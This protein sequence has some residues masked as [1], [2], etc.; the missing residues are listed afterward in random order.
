MILSSHMAGTCCTFGFFFF[1]FS[2]GDKQFLLV[3]ISLTYEFISRMRLCYCVINTRHIVACAVLPKVQNLPSMCDCHN[4]SCSHNVRYTEF[5]R[6]HD[7]PILTSLIIIHFQ[8]GTFKGLFSYTVPLFP[9]YFVFF[10]KKAQK[11]H[12]L[13]QHT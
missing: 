13:L 12:Y 3:F 11:P 2:A 5:K 8:Q 10:H 7:S 4:G 1:S 9:P 6:R